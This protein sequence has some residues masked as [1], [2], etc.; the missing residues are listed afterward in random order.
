MREKKGF[1]IPVPIV[2]KRGKTPPASFV[3]DDKTKKLD[4]LRCRGK[5]KNH[6][7]DISL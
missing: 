2:K 5:I 6:E 3:I 1:T 7:N 4:R